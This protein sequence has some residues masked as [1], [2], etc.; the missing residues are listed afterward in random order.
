MINYH[1]NDWVIFPTSYYNHNWK[2]AV[3]RYSTYV[4]GAKKSEIF[5]KKIIAKPETWKTTRQHMV[6]SVTPVCPKGYLKTSVYSRY[7][8]ERSQPN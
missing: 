3:S 7:V 2:K 1:Q 6:N 5:D 4:I 8:N